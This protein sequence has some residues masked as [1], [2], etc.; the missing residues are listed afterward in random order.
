LSTTI[1]SRSAQQD[2]G[3]PSNAKERQHS[4]RG[5]IDG[6]RAIAV[7][8]VIANH[9]DHNLLPGGF[10]GVD[11][12]F[13]ISGFVITS[14]LLSRPIENFPEFLF[15]F[16]ERRIRRI[17]P[18]LVCCV[19]VTFLT[20]SLFI[21]P[22]T[23]I[24]SSTWQTGAWALLGASNIYLGI[25]A[26][27]YFASSTALNPFTQTWS[28]G[29]E[30]QFYLIYPL[31]FFATTCVPRGKTDRRK[32]LFLA[33]GITGALS[34]TAYL[35]I[36][37]QNSWPYYYSPLRFWELAAGC[38]AC[39][40]RPSALR[41][42]EQL[43]TLL[44]W[45]SLATCFVT[46]MLAEDASAFGTI[47]TVLAT[48]FLLATSQRIDLLYQI[49]A[50]KILRPIGLGS[51]SIYLWHWSVLAIARWTIGISSFSVPWLLLATGILSYASYTWIETPLRRA[52]WI[53]SEKGTFIIGLG[54]LAGGAATLLTLRG[55]Q[56]SPIYV[57]RICQADGY[58][59]CTPPDS[60]HP[61]IT[62]HISNT[63]IRRNPCFVKILE[64][65]LTP[66][67]LERC[68]AIRSP[69]APTLYVAGDS[70]AGA[71]S[72]AID[73][74]Y[75]KSR[76]N[77][78]YLAAPGCHFNLF[79]ERKRRS[80]CGQFNKARYEFLKQNTRPGDVILTSATSGS[81]YSKTSLRS[82]AKLRNDLASRNVQIV[83]QQVM[84]R[85]KAQISDLCFEPRQVYNSMNP[86]IAEC[87][88][89]SS[90]SLARY[91]QTTESARTELAK[92]EDGRTLLV[93]DPNSVICWDGRCHSHRQGIRLF[94][95]THHFSVS[96][97]QRAG[98]SLRSIL[99]RTGI[100]PS[101]GEPNPS[102]AQ[103]N[104]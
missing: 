37:K 33:V 63:S 70:F 64:T 27:D 10:L 4:H 20:A 5:D 62:P 77:L 6:L 35:L 32:G 94:R 19:I 84:P 97:A 3:L 39:L 13:V 24:A 31:L 57:G 43:R 83:V 69:E 99:R 40:L 95:D 86:L 73:P 23:P 29:V 36:G 17:V 100:A 48:A 75:N 79:S 21:T 49:L 71:L 9:I 81:G 76:F 7:L 41:L 93:W 30:E 18:A 44:P 53:E 68:S 88:K 2:A 8:A 28:L 1:G 96:G 92:L 91:L 38:M 54:L 50:C 74:L 42:P 46:L 59:T 12:F 61:P 78:V 15:G 98:E 58:E 16:Y 56:G 14:S 89:S 60:P 102:V 45:L 104:S 11:M 65:G 101:L 47:L 22:N 80:G 52:P 51:Y 66:K 55:D 90:V 82:L 67:V 87:G 25:N 34:L 26:S 72:P 85:L 103:Q